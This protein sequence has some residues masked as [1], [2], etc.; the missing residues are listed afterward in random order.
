MKVKAVLKDVFVPK[1]NDNRELP[2]D[3][4]IT[5]EIKRP[6]MGDR[7]TL[8]SVRMTQGGDFSFGYNTDRILRQYVGRITNLESE[9]NGK[10][11][12]ITDGKSLSEDKNPVL[13]ALVTEIC[14][15][16]TG[17]DTLDEDEVKN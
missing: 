12:V 13:D 5:V 7:S 10:T 4:Q 17:A 2:P 6:T 15:E 9:V 11:F 8:K 1:F 3:Q 16:V 14:M